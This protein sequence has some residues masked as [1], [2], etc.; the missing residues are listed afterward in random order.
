MPILRLYK[1]IKQML[2]IEFSYAKSFW[3]MYIHVREDIHICE[4]L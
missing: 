2:T 3:I 1:M 4:Q